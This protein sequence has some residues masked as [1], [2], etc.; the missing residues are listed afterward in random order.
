MLMVQAKVLGGVDLKDV[1]GNQDGD[2]VVLKLPAAK[3]TEVFID[4]KA[5]KVWDRSI[6]WWAV[7]VS[8]NPDLEQ[9]ARRAA[10]ADVELAAQQMGIISNAQANAETT[11]REFLHTVGVTNVVFKP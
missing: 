5:T 10:L 2:A 1:T 4:D 9:S 3:I 8:P 6:S 7:W 11:I